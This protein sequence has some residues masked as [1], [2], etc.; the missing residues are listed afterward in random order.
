[1]AEDTARQSRGRL[2]SL[3]LLPEDCTDDVV[4][5]MGELNV[6][7]RSQADILFE[8]NDRLAVKGAPAISKSAFNRVAVRTAMAARRIAESRAVFAGIADK[9]TPETMDETNMVV[10]ELIKLLIMD[11]LDRGS[12]ALSPKNAMELASGYLASIRGQRLSSDHRQKLQREFAQKTEKA[13][14]QVVKAAGLSKET[15]DA[16]RAQILGI[17]ADAPA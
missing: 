9:F 13:V 17:K 12:D 7:K 4:W 10:G 3:D 1:M 15:G 2:S 14:D 6:R 5:A 11:V 8:L 16:I